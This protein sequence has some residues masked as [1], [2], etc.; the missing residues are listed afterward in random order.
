MPRV[1]WVCNAAQQTR[2]VEQVVAS[3]LKD[4]ICHSD[5]CQIGSFSSVATKC[6]FDAEP[7]SQAVDQHWVNVVF[8][9][10]VDKRNDELGLIHS[11]YCPQ[12]P[13]NNFNNYYK[14]H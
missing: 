14:S 2:G 5:E 9:G 3:E 13:F 6:W 8:A 7:G 4:P 1:C 11:L 10:S 12:E